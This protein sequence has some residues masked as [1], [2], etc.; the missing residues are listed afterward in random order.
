M[1]QYKTRGNAGPQGKQK[2][3]FTC[4]QDDFGRCFE[5]ITNQILDFE[6]CALWYLTSEENYQDIETELG[7]MRLFVI[8]VTTKLLTTSSRT[9]DI[10]LPFALKNHIPVLPLMQ[11]NGLDGLF[12]KKFGSLHYLDE[13]ARDDTAAPY[14]EKL[15]RYLS[16]AIVG[17]ELA[18]KVRA[19]FDAYIFLSYRKKDRKHA[20]ELMRLI[21]KNDF[22]RDIAI[23]YDEFLTPGENFNTEIED[24]LKKASC[25]RLS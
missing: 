24:A 14:E 15:K 19:A 17:D 11:E 6:N 4:H 8:P 13:N 12:D 20:Q 10:D 7:G 18:A 2:V 23:W 3:Y 25:L 16:S 21:H 9:M 22:C 5:K 1:L